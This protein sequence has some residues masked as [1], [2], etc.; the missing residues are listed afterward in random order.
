MIL[1]QR[2]RLRLATLEDAK[3]IVDFYHRNKEHL[4]KWD[5][6]IPDGFYTQKYWEQ[7]INS[8]NEEFLNK[9]SL[10]LYIFLPG[11]DELIGNI[12][13]TTFERGPFQNCRVGYKIDHEYEG[14]GLMSESLRAACDY[15]FRELNF[16]RIEANYI[17]SN[18]KSGK[19]LKRLGFEENG[20][21]KN[22]LRIAGGWQDHN[23]TSL[24]NNDWKDCRK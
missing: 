2:C 1:T 7:R 13:F 24:I 21:A 11:S 9:E 6:K 3:S 20:V 4:S 18:K 8:F 16:H 23:L 10:R 14:K 17:P 22:Y 19:L 12:N 15:I 5:P